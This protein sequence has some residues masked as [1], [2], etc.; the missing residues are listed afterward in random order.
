MGKKVSICFDR[1][2]TAV[3]TGKGALE[4]CVY[5]GKGER[6]WETVGKTSP[7]NWMVMAQSKDILLKMEHYQYIIDAMIILNQKLTI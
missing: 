7:N 3:K 1:R 4:I 5:L 2:K 6:M